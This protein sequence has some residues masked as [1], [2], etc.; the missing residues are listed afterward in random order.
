MGKLDM[1]QI[2]SHLIFKIRIILKL[3]INLYFLLIVLSI[4]SLP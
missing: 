1:K 4:H 2:F 3:D